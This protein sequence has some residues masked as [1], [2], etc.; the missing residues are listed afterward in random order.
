M[1]FDY[2][3]PTLSTLA[4][5][6]AAPAAQAELTSA[7]VWSDWKTYM[8]DLGYDMTGI[9][10]SNAQGLTVEGMKITFDLPQGEGKFDIDMGTTQFIDQADGSVRIEMSETWRFGFNIAPVDAET[11]TGQLLYTQVGSDLVVSGDPTQLKYDFKADSVEMK[12]DGLAVDGAPIGPEIFAMTIAMSDAEST[13][14]M[15]IG[16]TR[17]YSQTMKIAATSYNINAKDPEG[18]GLIKMQGTVNSLEFAGDGVVPMVANFND[19]P[20]MLKAGFAFAGGYSFAGG[21][22][23]MTFDGPDGS[24]TMN[25]TS[26]GGTFDMNMSEA[27]LTYVTSANAFT[28]N[29]LMNEFPIPISFEADR[30]TFNFGMPMLKGDDPQDFAFGTS[31]EGFQ[32]SDTIWGLFDPTGQLPRD[33][34]TVIL[35]LTGKAKILFD[36][37]D[38]AQAAVI[39]Q[40]GAVPGELNSVE[41]ANITVDAVGARLTGSGAFTFDNSDTQTFNGLPRP[42]GAVDFQLLGANGLIDKLTGMG[43]LPQEQAMGAR[44]MLGIFASPGEGEDSLVSKIEVNDQGHVLANGQRLQ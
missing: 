44:M 4:F 19:V 32:M 27:G 1:A 8:S 18:T 30:A 9:E 43:L 24:G 20:N 13:T 7:E 41:L 6:M 28:V 29:A 38:P 25:T 3:F 31:F 39:E 26:E 16:D 21:S 33:P 23:A 40:S 36:F 10:N 42:S 11:L 17:N 34:A 15:T 2:R 12:L 37:L 14:D 5:L 35:D 22:N